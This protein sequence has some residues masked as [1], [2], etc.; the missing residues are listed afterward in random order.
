MFGATISEAQM[1][2]QLRKVTRKPDETLPKLVQR[3]MAVTK[4]AVT[5]PEETRSGAECQTFLEAIA[6]NRPLYFFVNRAKVTG[7]RIAQMLQLA[8]NYSNEEGAS[9][10]WVN[11]LVHKELEKQGITIKSEKTSVNKTSTVNNDCKPEDA[12]SV[13]AFQFTDRNKAKSWEEGYNQITKRL[14]EDLSIKQQETVDRKIQNNKFM[15]ALESLQKT[16]KEQAEGLNRIYTPNPP[17]QS[18]NY[19]GNNYQGNNFRGNSWPSRPRGR[20]GNYRG[21]FRGRGRGNWAPGR[22]NQQQQQ[23]QQ[24]SRFNWIRTDADGNVT[25]VLDDDGNIDWGYWGYPEEEP[26]AAVNNT[27]AE[28]AP[29]TDANKNE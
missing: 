29:T 24:S 10:E 28:P 16:L 11:E 12:A 27:Q 8:M 25:D 2:M 6:D 23:P 21:G 18:N 17:Y 20:G 9:D 14:N 4:R 22:N 3:I 13:N 15:E 1:R 5:V 26:T 7:M 19:Q